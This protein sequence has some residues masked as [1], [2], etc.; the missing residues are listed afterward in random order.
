M[1]ARAVLHWLRHVPDR[2]RQRARF[3]DAVAALGERPRPRRV[4]I[5]CQGNICRSPFAA[6][7]LSRQ[8]QV[9][10][11]GVDVESAGF[12]PPGRPSP[13]EAQATAAQWDVDLTR[14][15]SRHLTPQLS[16][17]ADLIVVMEPAQRRMV[18]ERTGRLVGGVMVLGDFD[19]RLM[20]PRTIPD[21]I[22]EDLAAYEQCYARIAR[23]TRVLGAVVRRLRPIDFTTRP[24]HAHSR[25]TGAVASDTAST[26]PGRQ[27]SSLNSS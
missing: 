15:R 12:L 1:T 24:I 2:A 18:R 27:S 16:Q 21:P 11:P 14:H 19:P 8:L 13:P 4:L 5:L 23:C 7:L 6:A 25:A 3:R 22:D 26:I 17:A 9:C 20:V 10:D